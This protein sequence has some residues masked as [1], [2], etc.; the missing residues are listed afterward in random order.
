MF[1]MS[2][3]MSRVF[4]QENML[5]QED[6]NM[7]KQKKLW[8]GETGREGEHAEREMRK[9]SFFLSTAYLLLWDLLSPSS[10]NIHF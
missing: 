4:L 9:K 5:R 10:K 3:I 8:G 1:T 6:S 7:V 2:S